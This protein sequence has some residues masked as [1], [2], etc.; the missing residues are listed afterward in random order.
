MRKI[1]YLSS[2]AVLIT[3]FLLSSVQVEAATGPKTKAFFTNVK[4]KLAKIKSSKVA[5]NSANLFRSNT[6]FGIGSG[7][8]LGGNSFQR[9]RNND[10]VGYGSS[11]STTISTPPSRVPST[12]GGGSIRGRSGTTSKN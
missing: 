11:R 12:S 6:N 1:S 9:N 4:A 7:F 2:I 8:S 5:V 3:V 10:C